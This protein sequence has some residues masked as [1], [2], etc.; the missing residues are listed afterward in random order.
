MI[1]CTARPPKIPQT[2]TDV[3]TGN[4]RNVD[5]KPKICGL[6]GVFETVSANPQDD[7]LGWALVHRPWPGILTLEGEQRE[8]ERNEEGKVSS[9]VKALR[10][11][12]EVGTNTERRGT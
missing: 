11:R 10:S 4:P 7:G 5:G 8:R 6:P 1:L 9:P 2:R 12:F 3:G